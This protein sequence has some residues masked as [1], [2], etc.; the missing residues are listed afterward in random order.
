MCK[1]NIV[2]V[3][4]AIGELYNFDK[5]VKKTYK[6]KTNPTTSYRKYLR[7][8]NNTIEN[9]EI[10]YPAEIVQERIS[11][12]RQGENWASIPKELFKNQ[13][14]NRHSSAY[15]R[16]KETD[17]S[18]TLDTGNA[19]SNYFHPLY[20]RIPTVREAARIQSFRDDFVFKGTRSAQYRQVG[21]AVPPLLAKALASAI[22]E[23]MN[24]KS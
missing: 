1:K 21:N 17:V 19:H 5:N 9:H 2:T 8:E 22:L 24:E 3:E 10:K 12:V 6:L 16:L 11:H 13:R 14:S 20:N 7:S 23:A 18:V 4:D 15:K